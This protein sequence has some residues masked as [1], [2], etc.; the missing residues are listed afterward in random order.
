MVHSAWVGLRG[1]DD[2][3]LRAGAHTGGERVEQASC[4]VHKEYMESFGVIDHMDQWIEAYKIPV[5]CQRWYMRIVFWMVDAVCYCMW[6]ICLFYLE[7]DTTTNNLYTPFRT[8]RTPHRAFLLALGNSL[9]VHA[10]QQAEV[11]PLVWNGGLQ[12]D[13]HF[14]RPERLRRHFSELAEPTTEPQR[15]R[16]RSRL[17]AA[18]CQSPGSMGNLVGQRRWRPQIPLHDSRLYLRTAA[19]LDWR[20][21]P[22]TGT[23]ELYCISVQEASVLDVSVFMHATVRTR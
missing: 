23:A 12:G 22:W 16:S 14:Y 7:N 20:P 4:P 11:N 6:R 5:K 13:V 9:V 21:H 1:P 17:S 15:K 10:Q 2:T 18:I 3:V 19:L 8:G